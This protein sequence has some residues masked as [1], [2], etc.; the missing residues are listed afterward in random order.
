VP[1]LLLFLLLLYISLC[2]QATAVKQLCNLQLRCSSKPDGL[3][4]AFPKLTRTSTMLS[5]QVSVKRS[6]MCL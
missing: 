6:P 3:I 4:S 2:K 1:L 5:A